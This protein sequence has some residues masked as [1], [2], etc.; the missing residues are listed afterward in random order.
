MKLSDHTNNLITI[1][2][3]ELISNEK[4]ILLSQLTT[5]IVN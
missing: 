2:T 5:P 3:E 1:F 4:K